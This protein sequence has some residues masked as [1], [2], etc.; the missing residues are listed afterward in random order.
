MSS[1]TPS[2]QDIISPQ[3]QQKKSNPIWAALIILIILFCCCCLCLAASISW[4][5]QF[6]LQFIS[7]LFG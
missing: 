3:P 2:N 5:L 6:G 7:G 1:Y 4:I